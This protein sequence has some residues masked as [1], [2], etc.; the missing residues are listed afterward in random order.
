MVRSFVIS[1]HRSAMRVTSETFV[2]LCALPLQQFKRA[3]PP[4]GNIFV[5][6]K[7]GQLAVTFVL[8]LGTAVNNTLTVNAG[9]IPFAL[10]DSGMS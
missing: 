7:T 3:T 10:K 1:F 6:I 8:L 5:V 2:A 4:Y 9:S